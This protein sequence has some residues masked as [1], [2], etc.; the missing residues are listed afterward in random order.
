MGVRDRGG[1]KINSRSHRLHSRQKKKKTGMKFTSPSQNLSSL[2]HHHLY[3]NP[4]P[5][6]CRLIITDINAK[7]R[8]DNN[9][10]LSHDYEFRQVFYAHKSNLIKKSPCFRRFFEKLEE[11][12]STTTT[13]TKSN[14]ENIEKH[15]WQEIHLRIVQPELARFDEMLH[16]IETGDSK[17]WIVKGIT[18]E[19]FHIV[20]QNINLLELGWEAK[21]ICVGFRNAYH[22][23][24]EIRRRGEM[25]E[26]KSRKIE[27]IKK[28]P[29]RL[30]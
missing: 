8:K 24:L 25:A 12:Q 26:H 17:R 6:D 13:T 23:W 3:Y 14:C 20:V 29:M 19:N 4:E 7:E 1:R 27:E 21:S 28:R 15:Q 2:K 10:G 5:A 22:D 16:W 11:A 18:V 30:L 9:D